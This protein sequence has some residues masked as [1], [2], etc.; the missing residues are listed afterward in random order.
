MF[1][2]WRQ[3]GF[4]ILMEPHITAG[5]RYGTCTKS[6]DVIVIGENNNFLIIMERRQQSD[7]GE[8]AESQRSDPD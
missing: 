7:W 2:V 8:G 3:E 1:G 6:N 4:R 5:I